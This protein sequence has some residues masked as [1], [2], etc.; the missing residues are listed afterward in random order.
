MSGKRRVGGLLHLEH[1]EDVVVLEELDKSF[2]VSAAACAFSV[3]TSSSASAISSNAF[4]C[5]I[6]ATGMISS[7]TQPAGSPAERRAI[8][9]TLAA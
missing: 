5:S 4:A 8:S 7:A 9:E 6:N 1:V 2:I 3:E